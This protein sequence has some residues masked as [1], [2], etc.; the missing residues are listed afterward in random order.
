MVPIGPL[1]E[2]FRRVIRDLSLSSGK[3]VTLRINGEKT[4]LDKRMIDELS[5]PLIH[6]VRNAVDHGLESP[7][8][9]EAVGKPRAGTVSLTASHRGHSVMITVGDDGHGIDCERIR[10]KESGRGERTDRA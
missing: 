1:F 10:Q 3:E 9:R 6:M 2:R 5:D 7:E 8:Q 4:E